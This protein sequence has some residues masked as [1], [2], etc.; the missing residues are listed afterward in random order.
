MRI[1]LVGA[2][3]VGYAVAATL[4]AD[5]HDLVLVENDE[6]RAAKAEA[7]LD[8]MVVRGNGAR[9]QVLEE[10][11][12]HEGGHT[13]L[14]VACSNRDEVNLMACWIARQRGVPRAI[15]RAV[16]M[17]FTD[18]MNWGRNLGIERLISPERAVA[19]QIEELLE[20]RSASY[21]TELASD[22]AGIYVF[23][24]ASDSPSLGIPLKDLRRLHPELVTLLL[25]IRRGDR[26]FIPKAG[27]ALEEGDQ[28]ATVCYREQLPRIEDFFRPRSGRPLRRV[29][30]A[31]GGKVG[32]QLSLR[33][34]ERVKS[35][36]VRLVDIDRGKCE[37]LAKGLP[38][39][40]VL[41]GDA[42]D[43]GL[44]R[45]EGIDS[46]DGFVATTESDERNLLLACLG[47]SLGAT[48][49]IA[50]IRRRSYLNLGA[51]L[52]LDAVINRNQ[53]LSE[54]IIQ[55]VRYPTGSGRLAVL[56]AIGA[57]TLEVPIPEDSPALG[58]PLKDVP[59]PEG[60]IL[61]LL[62]REGELFIPTGGTSLLAGDVVVIFTTSDL[63]PQALTA[64][65]IVP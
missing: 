49:S 22:R 16:G 40:L 58:R 31:G 18:S 56:D 27:D 61:G 50:V 14:F 39:I 15:A 47:K 8:V 34:V 53:A 30:I 2:G 29:I 33:I 54:G 19:R 55:S 46:A 4:A 7:E 41:W 43:E 23:R 9:P 20:V 5:G 38:G 25:H 52:P 6:E 26:G 51:T 57:E 35:A 36:Q 13:D 24:V 28:V 3:E 21:A 42:A 59:L 17:E 48:K 62:E 44:L 12:I 64:L 32:F 65:G 37:R 11:G 63:M 1:V 45:S 60:A 10:A